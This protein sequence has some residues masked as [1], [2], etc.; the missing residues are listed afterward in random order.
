[1][2]VSSVAVFDFRNLAPAEIELG[3]AVNLIWGP[4]G[5]GKTNV[6]ESV[7]M[8]LAGRSCRTNDDRE[9]IRF[10]EALARSEAVVGDRGQSRTFLCSVSRSEGRRHLVD[11]TAPAASVTA[12]RPPLAV[13]MPDRL[14]LIKGAPALRRS[15][16][17][18]FCAALWPA[19]SGERRRYAR[20]LAQ[21]NALLGRIRAGTASP[22]SLDAWD[23]ELALAGIELIALRAAALERLGAPFTSAAGELGL[24]G[25]AKIRYRPRSEA[26]A[27]EDLLAELGERRDGDLARG[28]SGW[29]PHLDEIALEVDRRSLRR[30]GSQG[31]QRLTLLALLFAE[32]AALLED[33][34]P[35][36][37]MILDDVTSELDAAR[38]GLLVEK[39][40]AGGGQ[41]L[42]T[43]TEPDQLPAGV[44]RNEVAIRDG[45]PLGATA[46][47]EAAA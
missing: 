20:A 45:R 32:R 15:H 29:G 47:S 23:R 39:L 7:Y 44:A 40:N 5:A 1:M 8:A 35:P 4:N 36:P 14:T 21:R 2:Y 22:T 6:L 43:A 34:R 46:A 41:A 26:T 38:R 27:A 33:G 12:E 9:A 10:G 11:G 13:F 19:R 31:Q 25:E 17:D 37:L 3:P 18:G 28:Y 30:Y 16:L 42:I 24:A